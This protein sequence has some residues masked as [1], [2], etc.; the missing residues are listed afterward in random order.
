MFHLSQKHTLLVL[1]FAVFAA[2]QSIREN[3]YPRKKFFGLN[4]ENL[5][6]RKKIRHTLILGNF[7]MQSLISVY[8]VKNAFNL[9]ESIGL[10]A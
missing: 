6:P 2:F 1:S 5:Y 7:D 3:L 8:L 9:H 4:R 10:L